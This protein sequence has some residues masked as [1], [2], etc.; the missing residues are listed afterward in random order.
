[1]KYRISES[2]YD[3]LNDIWF[4][5]FQKWSEKQASKYF[6]DLIAEIELISLNPEKGKK[7]PKI[8]ID[9]FYFR[10][11]SHYVFY[12][13]SENGIEVVRVLHKMMD[14]SKHLE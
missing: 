10:A 11:L 5:T 6:E 2:A 7:M 12:K 1:M 3:D 9:F 13:R 8:R 14:F 4:Y